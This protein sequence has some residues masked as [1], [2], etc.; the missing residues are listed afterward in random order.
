MR[1][2]CLCA[3]DFGLSDGV[4]SGILQLVRQQRLQA[5]SVLAGGA[6]WPRWAPMLLAEPA[7]RDGRVAVGLHFNLTDGQPLAGE[8]R[9]VWPRF[10]GL[11]SLLAR[12]H[13][14][15][16]PVAGLRAEWRA[17]WDAFAA[18]AGRPPDYVDGHQHVHH[19]PLV[20]DVVLHG[21]QDERQSPGATG[22]IAVRSTAHMLGP[23]HGF[24]RW[25]I[26]HSGGRAL[27]HRLLAQGLSHNAS[28]SGAYDF[29]ATDYRALMQAWLARLP[30]RG[31]MLFCH[32]GEADASVPDA[33]A[34]ARVRELSYLR[35]DA[36]ADDL[37]AAGVTLG[38]AW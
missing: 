24:K 34:Q 37:S 35:S 30:E 38:P 6:A 12:A 15:W 29:A 20:R 7:V 26:A 16:L 3:D 13:L 31:G 8:L 33:I 17:Q 36:F 14:R 21:L 2:L 23:G 25:V 32:P 19:L 28:L 22:R 18:A 9:A 10:P 5:V 4:C 1:T 27:G 11:L